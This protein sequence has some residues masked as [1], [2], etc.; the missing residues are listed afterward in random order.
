MRRISILRS[1]NYSSKNIGR[2][3][4]TSTYIH[5]RIPFNFTTVFNTKQA[6]A[7]VYNKL[8]EQHKEPFKSI[9]KSATDVSL[10]I[11]EGYLEDFCVIIKALPQKSEISMPG[12][13]KQFIEIGI[14]IAAMVMSTF[15]T[16]QITQLNEEINT[17]KEKMD[18]IL[19]VVHIHERH[20]HHLEEKM[21]QT[22][23]LLADLLES[24]I[25]FSSKV[26][27]AIEKKFQS[28]VHHHEN[29]VKSAQ[30]HRLA[31]VALPHDVLDGI[32]DHVV[33]VAKKKNLVPF[34]KFASDLFQIE[35]LHLYTP[36]T[37]EFTL[38]LHIPMVANSN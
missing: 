2:S 16:V 20:L 15:N 9:T 36:A 5:F 28:V 22:N 14:S 12:R 27:D 6:L 37:N 13:P 35:V 29:V 8:L 26:T 19:D 25:W 17:L 24:N 23:K 7:E 1:Q 30:H 18:L 4:A 33:N 38:I 10:A 34:V 21:D 31:P 32:I 3:T 11:I